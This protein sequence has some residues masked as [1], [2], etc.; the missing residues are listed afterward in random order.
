MSTNHT[1][2]YHLSQWLPEDKV[3]HTDF[4]EDNR[5]IDE[6]LA[7]QAAALASVT[8]TAADNSARLERKGNCTV[9]C[10]V[11]SGN[12]T[13]GASNPTV[14]AFTSRPHFVIY[15]GHQV[16]VTCAGML[17]GTCIHPGTDGKTAVIESID[18]KW[19]EANKTLSFY[20]GSARDQG[21]LANSTYEI[22][23]FYRPS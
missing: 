23:A 19:N 22:M 18:F 13:F 2:Y 1:Q 14:L 12:G 10:T 4:N 5:V 6:T 8:A 9:L 17:E 20:A 21:N 15:H 11:R 7:A 3:L 16:L